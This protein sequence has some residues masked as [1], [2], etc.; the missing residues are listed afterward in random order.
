[1]VRV[2]IHIDH[3]SVLTGLGVLYREIKHMKDY[4]GGQNYW[5][6]LSDLCD[7]EVLK[8]K[9][10]SMHICED[11]QKRLYKKQPPEQNE[12]MLFVFVKTF[13]GGIVE[14]VELFWDMDEAERAFKEWTE[15][16][17]PKNDEEWE[18]IP[19]SCR[20]SRIFNTDL[21]ECPVTQQVASGK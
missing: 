7:L 1:M 15:H 16:D 10:E 3:D 20:D 9:I 14:G 17:Y 12:R 18:E 13:G 6:P 8:R 21:P 4:Q 11:R 2:Y 19:E 5:L